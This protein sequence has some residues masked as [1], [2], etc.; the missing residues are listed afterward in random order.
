MNVEEAWDYLV[1][2]GIATLEELYLI[3]GIYGYSLSTLEDV[4][5]YREGERE[6]PEDEEEEEE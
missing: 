1:Y 3:T 5:Y 4:L 6:F 2:N